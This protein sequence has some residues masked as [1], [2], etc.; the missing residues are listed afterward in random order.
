MN[1]TMSVRTLCAVAVASL[2]FVVPTMAR[3]ANPAPPASAA[4]TALPPKGDAEKGKT[5]FKSVGCFQ[6]HGNEAQGGTMGPRLGPNP[7]PFPRLVAYVRAPLGEMPPYTAKVMSEQDLA[8]VYAF[9]QA[10]Q[11]PPAIGTIPLLAP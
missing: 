11:R 9:L 8:D 7:L 4:Q 5:L 2:L 6:C 1:M 3:Q 10:R